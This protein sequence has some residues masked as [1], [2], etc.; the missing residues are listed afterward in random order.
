MALGEEFTLTLNGLAYGGQAFGRLPDGRMAF[1]PFALPGETVRLRV[2]EERRGHVQGELLQVLEAAPERTSPRCAHFGEC[3][4]CHYQHLPYAA[5]VQAKSRILAEQ[6]ERLGQLSDPP[7][8]PAVPSPLETYYRNHIEF[9]L[10]PAGRLGFHRPRSDEVLPIRECWLPEAPL[11]E[12]WPQ[13]DFEALPEIERVG[14]RLGREDDIQLIL[15]SR[16]LQPP[17]VSVEELPLSV[18]HLS[19]AGALVLA[20]S[21]AVE[22]EVLGRGFRVSAGSFFQVHR[23]LAGRLVEGLLQGLEQYQAL[24]PQATVVEAFCG[25]GLFSAFL[26]PRVGRLIAIEASPQACEDFAFNLDEFD[27]VELYEGAAELVLPAL[28][29][30]PHAVQPQAVVLDPPRSGLQ[31]A[32]LDGLVQMRPPVLAYIS[33]DPATLARDGRR[34]TA[35]GYHLAQITPFDIFPQTYHIESLSFWLL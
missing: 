33:C 12:L 3:G 30:H 24:S 11:N 1:V 23:L 5:Q 9:H 19:P 28:N 16:D 6:L 26:A 17:Q 13:L 14:L 35:A 18:V 4:G 7:L 29:A 34:L 27:H 22:I 8:L 32:A 21:P 15:E 25:V 20:G 10:D 31:P 2:R